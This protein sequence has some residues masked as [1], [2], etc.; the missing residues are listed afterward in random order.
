MSLFTK[1]F[2]K[3]QIVGL[4]SLTAWLLIL[5]IAANS[6]G[7]NY[8]EFF[9]AEKVLYWSINPLFFLGPILVGY[10]TAKMNQSRP[11]L[12]GSVVG[13][14]FVCLFLILSAVK[15]QLAGFGPIG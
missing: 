8:E 4:F 2:A 6:L 3:S 10:L 14:L 5:F 11:W 7:R 1:S 12:S 9:W 15:D 13:I